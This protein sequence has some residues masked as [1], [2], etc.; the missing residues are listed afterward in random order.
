MQIE[1]LQ[2][3]DQDGGDQDDREGALQE[4]PGLFPQKL[5][6]VAQT[7]E[8]VIGQ[9]HYEGDCFTAEEGSLVEKCRENTGQDP[10]H[11]E[12]CHD[13]ASPSGEKGIDK[14]SI[15]RDFCRAAHKGRQQDRHA[16]VAVTG[17]CPGGHDGGDAASE[18]DQHGD[19]ASSR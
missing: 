10:Q 15:D 11:I 14:K 4:I 8:P 7:G 13:E 16:A 17:Q 1:V 12:A 2:E 3:P 18:S 6:G 5:Q 19:D 9:F